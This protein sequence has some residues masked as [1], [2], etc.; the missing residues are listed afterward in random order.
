MK[1]RPGRPGDDA[2]LLTMFDSAI[3]WLVSQNR[4]GQWGTQPFTGDP[5]R[6][7]QAADW[8]AGGGMRIAEIDGQPAGCI[9]VGDALPYV[10]PAT[11]PE[12]YVQVLVIDQRHAGRAIGRHLLQWALQEARDRGLGLVRVD[13]YAG[14]DERLIAYYESC[15]FTRDQPFTVGEWPGMILR[16]RP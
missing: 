11:E 5:R 7:Q 16:Q 10:T 13:C 9:V 3:T 4:T 2:V 6:T 15:G 12:L 14:D 8:L 1:I